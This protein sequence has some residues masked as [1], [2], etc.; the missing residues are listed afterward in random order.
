MCVTKASPERGGGKGGIGGS[1]W[2]K[3]GVK[4]WSF[5]VFGI[6]AKEEEER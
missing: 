1:W 6:Y 5:F 4:K 2:V 3:K